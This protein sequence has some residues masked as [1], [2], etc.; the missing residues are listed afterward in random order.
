MLQGQREVH[1]PAAQRQHARSR[2]ASRL[3]HSAY[4]LACNDLRCALDLSP[5]TKGWP[6]QEAARRP[7]PLGC[8]VVPARLPKWRAVISLGVEVPGHQYKWRQR[9]WSPRQAAHLDAAGLIRAIEMLD[10]AAVT[11]ELARNPG[12]ANERG[13]GGYLPLHAAVRARHPVCLKAVL[14]A[15]ASVD[16]VGSAYL[17]WTALHVAA[18]MGEAECVR[19][20][21]DAGANVRAVST[22]GY[23]AMHFAASA[24]SEACVKLLLAH[25]ADPRATASSGSTALHDAAVSNKPAPMRLLV[26]TGADLSALNSTGYTPLQLAIQMGQKEAT[27]ELECL[28]GNAKGAGVD[29]HQLQ[30]SAGAAPTT[31]PGV[32]TNAVAPAAALPHTASQVAGLAAATRAAKVATEAAVAAAAAAADSSPSKG[33]IPL[34]GSSS[35]AAPAA[36]AAAA[37]A[38]PAAAASAA[39]ATAPAGA[40]APAAAGPLQAP[41]APPAPDRRFGPEVVGS[42]VR[43]FWPERQG[44]EGGFVREYAGGGVH[45]VE[46]A[47]ADPRLGWQRVK[48]HQERLQLKEDG[49]WRQYEAGRE[50]PLQ[51]A[52]QQAQQAQQ[53]AQQQAHQAQQQEGVQGPTPA[54]LLP[55]T[56]PRLAA[57]ANPARTSG[58]REHSTAPRE[59]EHQPAAK[60]QRQ[61]HSASAAAAEQQDEAFAALRG[62]PFDPGELAALVQ[63]LCTPG[64]RQVEALLRGRSTGRARMVAVPAKLERWAQLGVLIQEAA[65]EFRRLLAAHQARGEGSL[66]A[67]TEL[68]FLL[69]L[70][71]LWMERGARSDELP[72]PLARLGRSPG[73]QPP[74]PLS[75]T[76][77]E[78]VS[79]GGTA[80]G[81]RGKEVEQGGDRADEDGEVQ[82]VGEGW[83]MSRAERRKLETQE[84]QRQLIKQEQLD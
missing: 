19:V 73:W 5:G 29:K 27:H 2:P 23:T 12:L 32:A 76:S 84:Q 45:L 40:A 81:A 7:H 59:R 60:R 47:V 30:H 70:V 82:I 8:E 24:G 20:L 26:E 79:S 15:G 65:G 55:G 44:F 62:N 54:A 34:A 61:E 36:L 37:A 72:A 69:R 77:V 42:V 52:R 48:L 3:L 28:Q 17:A 49:V 4:G 18:D 33:A 80:A 75:F 58:S 11:A 38:A 31:Q 16:A 22:G 74:P 1:W 9:Q 64:E 67:A 83:W 71:Q 63:Q 13:F 78:T 50:V 57:A 10:V 56:V 68:L 21:L 39:A 46:F 14:R 51:Q 25:G 53:Q 35:R 6:S 41:P 66:A 43:V